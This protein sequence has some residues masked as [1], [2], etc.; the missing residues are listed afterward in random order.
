MMMAS[1]SFLL[2]VYIMQWVVTGL[3]H[4]LVNRALGEEIS[5]YLGNIKYKVPCMTTQRCSTCAIPCVR[6]VISDGFLYI[7]WC[8]YQID[9]CHYSV[10][11]YQLNEK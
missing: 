2:W 10:S 1:Y 11:V 4:S 6:V 3:P 5:G 7:L 8:L 9:P